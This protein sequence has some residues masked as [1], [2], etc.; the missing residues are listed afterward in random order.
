MGYYTQNG[1][2]VGS[3]AIIQPKGVYDIIASQTTSDATIFAQLKDLATTLSNAT[4]PTANNFQGVQSL[5]EGTNPIFNVFAVVGPNAYAESIN[6]FAIAGGKR[7]H[8]GRGFNANSS[9]SNIISTGNAIADMTGGSDNNLSAIDGKKWMAMAQFDGSNF[10]GILLWVFTGDQVNNSGT[11]N[12]NARSVTNV[13]DIFY[14]AGVGNDNYHHFFPV[15]ISPNSGT[16][17]SNTNSGK[18]G[19]NFSNNTGAQSATGYPTS[20]HMS[21]DDGVWGFIIPTASNAAYVDGNSPGVDFRS[22]VS[23]IPGFGMG[24]YNSG[25]SSTDCYWNGANSGS[26]DQLGFVFSGDG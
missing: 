22:N 5:I 18:C 12:S 11:I 1:G 25:D 15:A 13:R 10:D 6:R 4:V 8:T 17:Y 21:N 14:P 26:N 24:N 16:I 9:S 23:T 19:W 20:N 3:G 7:T 2:L